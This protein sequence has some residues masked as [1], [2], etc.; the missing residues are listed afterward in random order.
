MYGTDDNAYD[1]L[2]KTPEGKRPLVICKWENS[3]KTDLKETVCRGV[4]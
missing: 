2:V 4:V 1:T 3:I